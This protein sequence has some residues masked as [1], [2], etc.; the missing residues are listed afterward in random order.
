M[1]SLI[2]LLVASILWLILAKTE[3]KISVI[4]HTFWF[5]HPRLIVNT[6]G[7]LTSFKVF[8]VMGCSTSPYEQWFNNFL[9]SSASKE[10]NSQS[11]FRFFTPLLP[12]PLPPHPPPS[13]TTYMPYER[14]HY[15]NHLLE[16]VKFWKCS[17]LKHILIFMA[18]FFNIGLSG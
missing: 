4:I 2:F 14:F 6:M 3:I 17:V 12:A 16:A 9:C 10:S 15:S 11:I 18:S 7:M 13:R 1:N 5:C 8:E